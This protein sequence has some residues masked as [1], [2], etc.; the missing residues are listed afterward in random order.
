MGEGAL[1]AN[2]IRAVG[3]EGMSLCSR[4]A[5]A[6]ALTLALIYSGCGTRTGQPV[7]PTA[8]KAGSDSHSTDSSVAR[9]LAKEVTLPEYQTVDSGLR[10]CSIPFDQLSQ[11][12]PDCI[13][14]RRSNGRR[15]EDYSPTQ[16]PEVVQILTVEGHTDT[17]KCTGTVIADDWVVTSAHCLIGNRA[18][19]SNEKSNC[20]EDKATPISVL[21]PFAYVLSSEYTHSASDQLRNISRQ[22]ILPSYS[23]AP[24]FDDDLA[25]LQLARPFPERAVQPATIVSGA[26]VS[27]I[28]TMA[29]YGVSDAEDGSLG[30]LNVNWP[31]V[32]NDDG[33]VISLTP[34]DGTAFCSGDSGGPMFAGRY[35]GC[36]VSDAAG[37]PRPRL[38]QAVASRFSYKGVIKPVISTFEQAKICMAADKMILVS[39][40]N[41]HVKGWICAVTA[42]KAQ[43][44]LHRH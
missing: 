1:G 33:D 17:L 44:C 32:A 42:N 10:D 2:V 24:R 38:L 9:P 15:C 29:G 6:S 4:M 21:A 8:T 27:K 28:T 41:P 31:T 18:A 26:E 16:F 35:R 40:A 20:S 39:V 13:A 14:K 43:G 22:C 25:L 36:K 34:T 23:G 3:D 12:A 5:K 30:Y 19:T 37:E 7:G 11:R